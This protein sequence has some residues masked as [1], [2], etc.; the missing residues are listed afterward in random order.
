MNASE[1]RQFLEINNLEQSA[2]VI[3]LMAGVY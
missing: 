3:W 2:E 1:K